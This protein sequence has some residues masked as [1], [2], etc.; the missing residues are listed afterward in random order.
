MRSSNALAFSKEM[1]IKIMENL[2]QKLEAKIK[3]KTKG[4]SRNNTLPFCA[5]QLAVG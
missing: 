2:R 4:K 5:I 3:K 1:M